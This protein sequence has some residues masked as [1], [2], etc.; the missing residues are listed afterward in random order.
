VH[1]HEHD[2]KA[3]DEEADG[4]QHVAAVPER[5]AHRFAGRLLENMRVHDAPL[6][7]RCSQRRDREANAAECHQRAHPADV[8]QQPL[9]ERQ[10]GELPERASSGRNAERHAALLRRERASEDARNDAERD[11]GLT[12]SYQH[13]C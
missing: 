11:T 12:G 7:H 8:R 9:R 4:E 1:A 13:A 3:A 2:L 5:F 6:D 10:H